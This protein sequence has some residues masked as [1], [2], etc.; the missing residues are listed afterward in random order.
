[1]GMILAE[2]SWFTEV[3]CQERTLASSPLRQWED[4]QGWAVDPEVIG[5]VESAVITPLLRLEPPLC[6]GPLYSIILY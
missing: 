2:P 4:V 6:E 1:M 3:R 5:A